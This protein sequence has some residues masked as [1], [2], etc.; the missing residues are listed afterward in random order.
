TLLKQCP[1][2]KILTTSREVLGILGEAAYFVPPLGIPDAEKLLDSYRK[3]ES[4]RLF[5]ERAQLARFDF[6]L[7]MENASSV[8][9]ICHRLDGIPLAIELAAV[10]VGQ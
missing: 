9:Q 7:T 5:E 3:F 10:H 2:L 6:S 4:V 8:A 1:N